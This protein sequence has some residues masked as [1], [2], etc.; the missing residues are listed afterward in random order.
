MQSDLNYFS[1]LENKKRK[2]KFGQFLTS[3][4][5][6]EFM[7]DLSKINKNAKVLE[8]SAG[9]GV[10][11][12]A[13][14]KK[15]FKKIDAIE[16]D[17]FFCKYLKTKYKNIEIKNED[18]LKSDINKKYNLIIGNPP[19]VHWNNINIETRN[20]LM[21][22]NFWKKYV[23]GEWDLFYAFIIWSI[24]KLKMNGEL[25]FIVPYNFFNSTYA[26]GLRKY[27]VNNGYF[28]FILHFGELKLFKDCS[29]NNII[30]SY[31]KSDIK[32][33]PKMMVCDY[34]QKKADIIKLTEDIKLYIKKGY[35][36]NNLK[37]FKMD[38]FKNE[39]MWYLAN[40]KDQ[41]IINII[42]NATK[43]NKKNYVKL[44]DY[45]NIGVGIVSG[46]DKA[47]IIKE[48]ELNKFNEN[49]KKLICGFIK[50]KNCNRFNINSPSYYIFTDDISYKE[51]K[52]YPNIYKRLLK[53]KHN[54][55]KRYI[56]KSKQWWQWATIRNFNLFQKNIN[57]GKIFVPCIDR[58]KKARFSYTNGPYYGSGDV[59]I[60]VKKNNK[61]KEDLRFVLSWL[62]SSFINN[63]YKI[64][65][66]KKGHRT[67]YTQSYVSKIPLLLIDWENKKEVEIY[68]KIVNLTNNLINGNKKEENENKIDN[69]FKEI[70][71]NRL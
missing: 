69:L 29:P 39:Y 51:L 7:V 4:Q 60:I 42:E 32:N 25:I 16:I 19:Y 33:K 35:I 2:I 41:K 27:L 11:I 20:F 26:E 34:K 67:Q 66:S 9:K 71:N 68:K 1:D 18:F 46:F 23:N 30:F 43:L 61:L 49:E 55:K 62:N 59:L 22:N 31:I 70:I 13:L 53:Y 6:A 54:L 12:D 28:R 5:I 48:E 8:P 24:E 40:E 47:F 38:N 64:K 57:K 15:G 3:E 44:S 52:T 21:N 50:A 63:W 17:P 56:S 10:F 36:S 45:F 37:C 14:I 65:G 58:S